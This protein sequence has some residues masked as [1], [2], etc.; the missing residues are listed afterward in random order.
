M[1]GSDRHGGTN[2]RGGRNI[3]IEKNPQTGHEEDEKRK[4]R[5]EVPWKPNM[6]APSARKEHRSSKKRQKIKKTLQRNEQIAENNEKT[7]GWKTPKWQGTREP[8]GDFF[9][10]GKGDKRKTKKSTTKTSKKKK[11][12][13]KGKKQVENKHQWDPK[14]KKNKKRKKQKEENT[15]NGGK[16]KCKIL[17]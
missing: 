10:R 4:E 7:Q 12:K 9:T 8:I 2:N 11:K 1:I 16:V 15:H 17:R 5:K 3:K 13:Y 6:I 14:K